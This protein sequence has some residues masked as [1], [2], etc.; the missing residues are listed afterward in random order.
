[1]G[2]GPAESV[3]LPISHV[4][5]AN[6]V[7]ETPD[8]RAI[9]DD[10]ARDDETVARERMLEDIGTAAQNAP[11]EFE[12]PVNNGVEAPA[13]ENVAQPDPADTTAGA[14]PNRNISHEAPL[15]PSKRR[16]AR[17]KRKQSP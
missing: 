15:P 17:S 16:Q 12:Q 1:V 10:A 2:D 4:P 3:D 9:G 8:A 7:F 6:G 13:S 5:G 11:T 14:R